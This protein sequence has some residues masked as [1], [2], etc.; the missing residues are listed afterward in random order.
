MKLKKWNGDPNNFLRPEK[1]V[2]ELLRKVKGSDEPFSR[3]GLEEFG[4]VK[5]VEGA[6]G[7]TWKCSWSKLPKENPNNP[8]EKYIY[9]VQEQNVFGYE[10]SYEYKIDGKV[11]QNDSNGEPKEVDLGTANNKIECTITNTLSP[12][13]RVEVQK[14]WKDGEESNQSRPASITMQLQYKKYNESD[15]KYQNYLGNDGVLTLS[16]EITGMDSLKIYH[17]ILMKYTTKIGKN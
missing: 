12:T 13:V 8:N 3:L 4:P 10:T 11:V 17:I 1:I 16:E 15:D 2:V 5:E 14:Y 7:G 9:K 6:L